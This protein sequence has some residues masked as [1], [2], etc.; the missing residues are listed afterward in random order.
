[1]LAN[2][3]LRLLLAFSWLVG[4][5]VVPEGLAAP[6]AAHLHG[7]SATVGFL[8]AAGPAGVLIGSLAFSRLLPAATRAALL[9]PLAAAAGLPLLACALNPDLA[10]TLVLWG[11]SGVCLA[12]QVQVVTEF[13]AAVPADIRGQGIAL[14]SSGL[15]AAQG[16]GLLA[17]GLLAQLTGPTTA[18]AAAGATA[19]GLACLAG[20]RRRVQ[21]RTYTAAGAPA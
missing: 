8:L 12:F 4:L 21:R 13:V 5:L 16:V 17:G 6:Y 7:G 20:V 10:A 15:L 14:A 11:L 3:Q 19:T 2:P 18:V 1:V 9:T